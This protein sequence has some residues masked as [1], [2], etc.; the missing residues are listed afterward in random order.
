MI[1]KQELYC[2]NCGGYVQFELDTE[3]E[4]NHVLECPNCGHEHCRVVKDGQITDLRW[5]QRNR[6]ITDSGSTFTVN[7][8]TVTYSITSTFDQYSGSTGDFFLY[9]S[10]MNTTGATA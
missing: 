4:G 8:S 2:H 1:E 5:D 10:W 3:Q 7:S 6:I 9:S